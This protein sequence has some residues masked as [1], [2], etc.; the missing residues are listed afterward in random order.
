MKRRGAG[1][2]CLR[3]MA[4]LIGAMLAV[5]MTGLWCVA[6]GF[7]AEFNAEIEAEVG[8]ETEADAAE[9][10]L[11]AHEWVDPEATLALL[12]ELQAAGIEL[13]AA[14]LR[15]LGLYPR[16]ATSL[17][18]RP[19]KGDLAGKL[20]WRGGW[21]S[22]RRAAGSFRGEFRSAFV[23][24]AGRWYRSPQREVVSGGYLRM[25]LAGWSAYAGSAGWQQGF[26]LICARPGSWTSLSV[27]ASLGP[28]RARAGLTTSGSERRVATGVG[29]A[30]TGRV[31]NRGSLTGEIFAGRS[32][33]TKANPSGSRVNWTRVV[34]VRGA[35]AHRL[36]MGRVGAAAGISLHSSLRRPWLAADLEMAA[37][38]SAAH[39][40]WRPL[41]AARAALVASGLRIEAQLAGASLGLAPPLASRPAALP[42]WD[43]WGWAARVRYRAS[44]AVGLGVLAAQGRWREHGAAAPRLGERAV[45]MLDLHWLPV[46]GLAL[47]ANYRWRQERYASWNEAAPWS[48]PVIS[49]ERQRRGLVL[50]AEGRYQVWQ[51]EVAFR[52]Y[53]SARASGPARRSLIA[54]QGSRPLAPGWQLRCHWTAA[55]G[56]EV[57]L[58]SVLNPLPGLAAFRHWGRWSGEFGGGL[59]WERWNWLMQGAASLRR[60][61]DSGGGTEGGVEAGATLVEVWL[62]CLRRW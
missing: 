59:Q 40:R 6:A 34:Q 33:P 31:G 42:G 24:V 58:V 39:A 20:E 45:M 55:W 26:G 53:H 47:T 7:D 5:V 27:A 46:V 43:G 37:W 14:D 17:P 11:T 60:G 32:A 10:D 51:M 52:S 15:R 62:R 25:A 49:D 22:D 41:W 29:F 19:A 44:G 36:L 56:D 50:R 54:W 30:W 57:D 4:V 8:A 28:G 2:I 18:Q 23:Q 48:P 9:L 1:R 61:E 21:R 16:R 13:S 3:I 35:G 12:E 38:R